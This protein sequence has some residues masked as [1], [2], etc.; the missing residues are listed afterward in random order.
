MKKLVN[1]I[2]SSC[3]MIMSFCSVAYGTDHQQIEQTLSNYIE[4][5]SFNRTEQIK[6]AFYRDANLYLSKK[7][8]DIWVVPS[9]EY[10]TWFENNT[11]D[12]FNGRIGEIVSID[13]DG[14]IA[15]A[16]VDIIIPKRNIVYTDL[17]LL[18]VVA[19]DWKIIGKTA[20]SESSNRT[21][22]RILFIVSSAT[23]HGDSD[24]PAGVSYSEVVKA[25]DTFSK[26][27]YTIDFVSPKGGAVSLS[28]V[29]TTD[30]LHKNYLYDPDF[31]YAL[32]HTKTPNEISAADYRAVHYIGGSNAMYEV[33][34]N[35]DIQKISMEVYEQHG[36]VVSAV[37]H[38]TAGIAFLKTQDGEYLVKGK[39]INGYPEQYEAKERAY[40]KEFPFLIQ[41]TI[42]QHGGKFHVAPRNQAHVEVDG[43][44]VTG[45]N[46][47]SS[48]LVALKT[49]EI[50]KQAK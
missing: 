29:T 38:G 48:E 40:F 36:G 47:L 22:E 44:I 7:E 1:T 16:K 5:S 15:Q 30:D 46:H 37:C 8:K 35:E 20:S 10:A 2:A 11:R 33:P 21:G 13:I 41:E 9:N 19:G 31:M 12:E 4:G 18:K 45:Q 25:Y 23:V 43:R 27:G 50:L 6:S 28:Y 24:L 34:M 3:L 42:E 49:V 32:A 17:F 26:A 39:N 14:D